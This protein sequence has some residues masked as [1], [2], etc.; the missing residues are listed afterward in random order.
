MVQALTPGGFILTKEKLRTT[1]IY[2]NLTIISVYKTDREKFVLLRKQQPQKQK[3]Y[4]NISSSL[5]NFDWLLKLQ[6]NINKDQK[7]IIYSQGDHFNGIL[8]LVNC[9]KRELGTE[10]L[11]CVFI[12][13]EDNKTTNFFNAQL[14][15][16]LLFNVWKNSQWGT[17]RYLPI[18]EHE[19]I[20]CDY[21]YISVTKPGDISSA[22]W[23]QGPQIAESEKMHIVQVIFL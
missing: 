16:G 19:E 6:E 7:L 2:P 9:L 18:D 23:L 12:Y 4:V 13:D 14:N 20:E 11:Q 8:G 17:Y 5:D 15:Q 10:N 22:K 3:F 21:R 1:C